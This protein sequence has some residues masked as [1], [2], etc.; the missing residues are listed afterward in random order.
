MEPEGYE[1][2]IQY[3]DTRFSEEWKMVST[4]HFHGWY[5]SEASRNNA[6]A[7][8]RATRYGWKSM[9]EYRRVRRAVGPVEA[10]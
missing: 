10:Y 5:P 7:Q 4:N 1:Y 2:G 9:S 6:I 8:L 3:R